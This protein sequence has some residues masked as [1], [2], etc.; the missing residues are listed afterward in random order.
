MSTFYLLPT[1]AAVGD[2]FADL[3]GALLPGLSLDARGRSRLA[4]VVLQS[5]QADPDVFFV[6]R[7]ELPFGE[8]AERALID[9]Y[10]ASAGDEVVEVRP[11]ARAG[12]FVSRRWRI[13]CCPGDP[14]A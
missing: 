3:L 12:E 11:A 8:A 6:P 1:R 5:L 10:G 7:D 9:G 14:S 13:A 4:D 2:R